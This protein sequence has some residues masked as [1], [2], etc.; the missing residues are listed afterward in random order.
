MKLDILKDVEKQMN[1]IMFLASSVIPIAACIYVLLFLGGTAIDSVVLLMTLSSVFIRLFE[2]KLGRLAKYFYVSTMP[3][4]G[5]IV[6]VVADDGRFGAMTQAYFLWTFLAVAYYDVSVV[7][8]NSIV[9]LAGNAIGMILFPSSYLKMENV[10]IWVF[11]VI[12]YAL[13]ILAATMITSRTYQ[14]FHLVEQKERETEGVLGNVRNAFDDLQ[15]SSENI[16]NSLHHFEEKTQK[17]VSATEAISNNT[18]SQIA[19]VNGSIEI[20]NDLNQLIINSEDRVGETV[21]NMVE[22][23]DKNEEGIAAI[24]ELSEKFQENINT[25]REAALRISELSQKSSAIGEIIE[26][27]D[28]IAKQTNLLA[29]N[30]AIEAARAGDAGKGFAVVADEINILSTSSSEATHKIDAILKD[31][32][33]TVDETSRIIEGNNIIV[34]EAQDKLNITVDVFKMILHSSEEVIAVTDMLKQ[35]LANIVMMKE[36]LF[37]SM[38]KLDDVSKQSVVTTSEINSSTE[39]QVTGVE[40][41]LEA[42]GKVQ[43][44]MKQLASVLNVEE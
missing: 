10:A 8:V 44:G 20:F 25:T 4:W 28:Q 6:I 13:V 17:I 36:N 30:A 40:N 26:S 29:L 5:I 27:I 14:L 37:Q 3:F 34:E 42:M 39:E 31:I 21:D 43:S 7:K 19:E 2:K 15:E 24:S 16:Y 9:T 11:I 23:K 41:I 38:Q 18:S 22:L 12:V 35:E 33:G 32:I 1:L